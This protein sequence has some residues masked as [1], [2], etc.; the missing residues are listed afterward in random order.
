MKKEFDVEKAVLELSYCYF[1]LNLEENN[2]CHFQ[3]I[4]LEVF[5]RDYA[6][7]DLNTVVYR[8][9]H[10]ISY[11]TVYDNKAMKLRVYGPIL[12]MKTSDFSKSGYAER[13]EIRY[14]QRGDFYAYLADLPVYNPKELVSIATYLH[15]VINDESISSEEVGLVN[16][17]WDHSIKK[18]S[19]I[20]D[21]QLNMGEDIEERWDRQLE[22]F[23]YIRE[24]NPEKLSENVRNRKV[25]FHLGFINDTIRN[26]KVTA[27]MALSLSM[28]AAIE[29]GL[30]YTTALYIFDLFAYEIDRMTD[31]HEILN[32]IAEIQYEYA[33]R[34]RKNRLPQECPKSL[35]KVVQYINEH[36]YESISVSKVADATNASHTYI[37]KQFKKYLGVT[38]S[39]YIRIEKIKEAK[40]LLIDTDMTLADISF[41]LG[42]S[43]QPQFQKVFRKVENTTPMTYR[44]NRHEFESKEKITKND[45]SLQ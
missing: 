17:N 6:H 36:L 3:R 45:T 21:L 12:A 37:S 18:T 16:N 13:Y 39:E 23:H 25:N 31:T 43:S 29:G 33:L 42:F 38:L 26:Y 19:R 10:F 8:P 41:H 4:M 9:D 32:I 40:R 34:V 44:S 1:P 14:S 27:Y 20:T 28:N 15:N 11:I 22:L 30:D 35:Q 7:R 5:V 24:G 2:I